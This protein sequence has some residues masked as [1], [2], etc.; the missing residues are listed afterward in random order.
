M[1][2]SIARWF[3]RLFGFRKFDVT[4]EGPKP[5]VKIDPV[6]PPVVE[7]EHFLL[8]EKAKKTAPKRT[9]NTRKPKAAPKATEPKSGRGKKAK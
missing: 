3:L 5:V 6:V 4:D 7:Q 9:A 8:T 2:K 1:F